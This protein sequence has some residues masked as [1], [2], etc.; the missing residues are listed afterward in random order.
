MTPWKSYE[1]KYLG[2]DLR[3]LEAVRLQHGL[4]RRPADARAELLE[5][6]GRHGAARQEGQ[7]VAA[8][9]AG[10]VT[11]SHPQPLRSDLRRR[12]RE[13]RTEAD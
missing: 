1:N 13:P 11:R 4:L 10:D 9:V 6:R 7:L 2:H 5:R 8:D 12:C 3:H